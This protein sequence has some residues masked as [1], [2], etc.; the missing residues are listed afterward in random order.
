MS[1][2]TADM[3]DDELVEKIWDE[4]ATLTRNDIRK[5]LAWLA[6]NPL[7]PSNEQADQ[8]WHHPK[9]LSGDDHY[10]KAMSRDWQ[11]MAYLKKEEPL[12]EELKRLQEAPFDKGSFTEM[13]NERLLQAYK[14]GLSRK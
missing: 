8:L 1:K 10:A 12:P 7:V 9:V 6:N 4:G 2:V 5:V 13:W 11:R 3:I 14:L